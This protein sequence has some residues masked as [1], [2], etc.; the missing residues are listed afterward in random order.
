MAER[1]P[2]GLRRN[3][4]GYDEDFA[5]WLDAQAALLRDGRFDELD[6]E[7]LADEVESVGK[8][9]FRALVSAIELTLFH[10]MKWDYQPELRSRSWRITI[11][12]Q[13]RAI[14]KLLE[15]NPSFKARLQEALADAYAG[16]PGE[17]ERETTIP[18]GRLPQ[19]CPYDWEQVMTRAHEFDPDR[20]WPN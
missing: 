2:S 15:D 4:P 17:I 14:E 18:L 1:D 10:M 6:I 9:E 11:H 20:P 7:H 19:V 13:R 16:V 8:S 12:N 5:A 3:Y